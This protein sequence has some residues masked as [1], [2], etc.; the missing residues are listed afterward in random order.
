ML[1]E[2]MES[3]EREEDASLEIGEVVETSDLQWTEWLIHSSVNR[4]RS[5]R[6]VVSVIQTRKSR[7]GTRL[8]VPG[9]PSSFPVPVQ[10]TWTR[11]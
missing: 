2:A 5:K 11:L 9:V 8:I 10:P 3:V 6:E 7:Q 1:S 4:D